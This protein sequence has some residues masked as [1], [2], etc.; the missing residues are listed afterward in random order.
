MA[1]G[2]HETR[3]PKGTASIAELVCGLATQS[4]QDA[5]QNPTFLV[6]CE[7]S[8]GRLAWVPSSAGERLREGSRDCFHDVCVVRRIVEPRNAVKDTEDS[9]RIVGRED[10]SVLGPHT[11]VGPH[12]LHFE[13][14]PTF[15]FTRFRSGRIDGCRV[16][17]DLLVEG[18]REVARLGTEI[19]KRLDC[20]AISRS[21]ESEQ[22]MLGSDMIVA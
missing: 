13:R 16:L 20:D 18:P 11:G 9:R 10:D 7:W 12:A 17:G 2:G 1:D 15:L 6:R 8:R 14:C 4:L 22:E 5:C 3:D 21:Q 19:P